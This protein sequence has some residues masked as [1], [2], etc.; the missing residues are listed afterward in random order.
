MAEMKTG[1]IALVN[2]RNRGFGRDIALSLAGDGADIV[3]TYNSNEA[4]RTRRA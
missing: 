4:R 2:S 3:L 1:R